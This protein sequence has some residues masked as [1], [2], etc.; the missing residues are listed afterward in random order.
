MTYR[1]TQGFEDIKT[2]VYHSPGETLSLEEPRIQEF[3]RVGVVVND[4]ASA[5]SFDDMTLAELKTKLV[6]KGIEYSSKAKKHDL[7]KLL[8]ETE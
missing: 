7:I 2:G 6:A 5:D 1:V 4:E 8:R 3:L